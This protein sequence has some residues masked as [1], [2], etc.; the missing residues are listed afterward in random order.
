MISKACATIRRARSFLP[1]LRPF[2]MRLIT[3]W[4]RSTRL[5]PWHDFHSTVPVHQS[6]N[7][8][9]LS[10]FELFLGV[11]TGGVREVYGMMDLDVVVEGN[12]LHFNPRTRHSAVH[13]NLS[14]FLGRTHESP[15]F[16]RA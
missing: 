7:N 13:R 5:L 6:L 3:N 15:T 12:I 8:R 1:L 14:D 9:H 16:Q 2:I 4:T 11:T 10:L